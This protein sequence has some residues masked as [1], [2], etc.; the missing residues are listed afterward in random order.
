MRMGRVL[1]SEALCPGLGAPG[2]ELTEW[3]DV[4]TYTA[5]EPRQHAGGLIATNGIPPRTSIEGAVAA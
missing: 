5:P 3:S 2:D 1:R 4:S